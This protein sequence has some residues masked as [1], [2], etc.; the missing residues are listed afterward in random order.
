MHSPVLGEW[1]SQGELRSGACPPGTP[2][3]SEPGGCG[4]HRH[5]SIKENVAESP[6]LSER[7]LRVCDPDN[8]WSMAGC[9]SL[10]LSLPLYSLCLPISVSFFVS[11]S[12][13]PFV[14][15]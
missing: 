8:G 7:E 12:L 15:I 14:S 6:S 9:L 3:C 13:F 11:A 5:L 2:V 1:E 4:S 10:T